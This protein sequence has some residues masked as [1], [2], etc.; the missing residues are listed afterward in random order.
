[1]AAKKRTPIE[2]GAAAPAFELLDHEGTP[3]GSDDLAGEAYVLWFF[4]KADTPG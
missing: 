1:M 2:E 4:P 3:F